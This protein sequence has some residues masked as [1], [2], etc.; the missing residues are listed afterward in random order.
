MSISTITGFI[1]AIGDKKQ[2]II[3][4]EPPNITEFGWWKDERGLLDGEYDLN[5]G[6]YKANYCNVGKIYIIPGGYD[7]EGAFVDFEPIYQLNGDTPCS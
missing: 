4:Q 6:V 3:L 1:V 5:P 7:S 2:L